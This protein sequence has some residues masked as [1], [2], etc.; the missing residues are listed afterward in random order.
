MC[1]LS[2]ASGVLEKALIDADTDTDT[3]RD[4]RRAYVGT[5]ELATAQRLSFS[6]LSRPTSRT[7]IHGDL[8]LLWTYQK[9][10]YGPP[11]ERHRSLPSPAVD[12]D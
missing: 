2:C 10:N 4:D 6:F 9:H 1:L 5:Q 8:S 11:P 12:T 3:S 7:K